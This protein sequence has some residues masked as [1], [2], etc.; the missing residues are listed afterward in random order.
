MALPCPSLLHIKPGENIDDSNNHVKNNLLPFADAEISLTV[1]DP[2]GHDAPVQDNE[3]AKVQLEHGGEQSEG[4]D[5]GCNGKE[6]PAELDD[7]GKVADGFLVISRVS[8]GFLV[9][10]QRPGKRDQR[11]CCCHPY[12][13]NRH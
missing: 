9:G 8:Q 4:D 1:D 6:V 13:T 11:G 12:N 7:D 10:G 2:E 3:D 5:S